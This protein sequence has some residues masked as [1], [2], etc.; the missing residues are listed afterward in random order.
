ESRGCYIQVG[1]YR[2]IENAF[3]M[4]RA[5]KKYYLTPSIRQASHGGT[6]V[7]HSVRLGPFQSSQELEAVGKLLNSKGF[8][9]YWVFYR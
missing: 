2:D 6:T 3:N 1:K 8:K 4:M 5:L 7:M 9:D